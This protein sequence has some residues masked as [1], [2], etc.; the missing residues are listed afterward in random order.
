MTTENEKERA[1]LPQD[2]RRL[3]LDAAKALM[4]EG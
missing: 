2:V 4:L 3:E 1:K